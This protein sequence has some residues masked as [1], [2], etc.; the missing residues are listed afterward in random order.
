M[1]YYQ[2]DFSIRPNNETAADI[3]AAV[4]SD[5]GFE[6]FMPSDSGISA[7]IQAAAFSREN[8]SEAIASFPMPDTEIDFCAR[9]L[10]DQDWNAEWEAGGFEPICIGKRL[11]IYDDRTTEAIHIHPQQAFGSGT[12]ATTQLMLSRLCQLPLHGA[13]VIDAGCGTGILGIAAMRMGAGSLV[14]FD[15]DEWSVN[16]S[17]DNCRDNG[18]QADIR[19]GGSEVLTH[20][21][22]ADIILANI[23]RNVLLDS[24]Q[25][26]A[27][28]LKPGAHLLLSG[29]LQQDIAILTQAANSC[30]LELCMH[31]NCNEWQLLDFTNIY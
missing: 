1:R 23:N 14:A 27:Q 15:I 10:P 24:M 8:I 19:L 28:H 7:Y 25:Q 30:A 4:L 18:V 16:N 13:A 22:Q 11:V 31:L 26:F 20:E 17:K 2:V 5:I 29:F 9:E 3:L 21:D 12:H 6:T